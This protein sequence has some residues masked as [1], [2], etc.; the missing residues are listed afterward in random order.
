MTVPFSGQGAPNQ[1]PIGPFHDDGDPSSRA[2]RGRTPPPK[3]NASSPASAT[4][5]CRMKGAIVRVATC[6]TRADR[7]L[8]ANVPRAY[9]RRERPRARPPAQG[10][11]PSMLGEANRAE[12]PP[13]AEGDDGSSG[14]TRPAGASP[15]PRKRAIAQ[16]ERA[17]ATAFAGPRPN[18]PP[19]RC[20]RAA[21]SVE[22]KRWGEARACR[23]RPG[24]LGAPQT[25][26]E[27]GRNLVQSMSRIA[28]PWGRP[29]PIREVSERAATAAPARPDCD[30]SPLRRRAHGFRLPERGYQP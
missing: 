12:R 29:P 3:V 13:L 23:A 14:R 10:T 25:D 11:V 1:S 15:F 17:S 5:G 18:R 19:R 6:N 28:R 30:V 7:R 22:T 27:A 8:P 9:S 26:A 2:P 4:R 20:H 24:P 21:P 16:R